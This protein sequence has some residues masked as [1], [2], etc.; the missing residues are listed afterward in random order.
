MARDTEEALRQLDAQLQ[1]VE[2]EDTTDSNQL[3]LDDV[4]NDEEL[5]QLLGEHDQGENPPVYE[6]FSNQYGKDLRNFASD[7]KAYNADTRVIHL[8]EVLA[9]TEK[10]PETAEIAEEEPAE[11][12]VPVQKRSGMILMLVILGLMAVVTGVIAWMLFSI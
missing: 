11:E 10:A 6:N 5:N 4:L 9:E 8:D 7:Y 1:E 3:T 2:K 12:A